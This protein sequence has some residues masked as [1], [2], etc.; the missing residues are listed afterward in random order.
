MLDGRLG[1]YLPGG[2]E[3]LTVREQGWSSLRN[4]ELLEAAQREFDAL[5][6][7]DRGVPCQQNL[8][9]VDL[10]AVVLRAGSNARE[11]LLPLIEGIPS[12]LA[13]ANPGEAVYVGA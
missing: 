13:T 7:A 8:S 3:A 12:L 2:I 5:L 1:R 6:T 10:I 9:R 4:G 11:D